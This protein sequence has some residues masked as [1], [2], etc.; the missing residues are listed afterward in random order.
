MAE[1]NK[2][3]KTFIIQC[4]VD[5]EDD[6]TEEWEI[7]GIPKDD[8]L[9]SKTFSNLL[10]DIDDDEL[11]LPIKNYKKISVEAIFQYI[12]HLRGQGD[13][14]LS[15]TIEYYSQQP[16]DEILPIEDE[17][18]IE[19]MELM[20]EMLDI[21]D[22]LDIPIILESLCKRCGILIK[23]KE[24]EEIRRI[25]DIKDDFSAEEKAEIQRE[26]QVINTI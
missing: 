23:G 9:M 13:T 3:T 10:D 25:F 6:S 19:S 12:K 2:D 26:L 24:P 8:I 22:F 5:L 4:I 21:A 11:I 18:K 20:Q 17:F 14:F 7:K 15:Q 1:A 16:K